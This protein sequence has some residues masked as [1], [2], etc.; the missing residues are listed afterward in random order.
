MQILMAKRE[1]RQSTRNVGTI[2][3]L[4]GTELGER[5]DRFARREK[6]MGGNIAMASA[7]IRQR[8]PKQYIL[9]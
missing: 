1:K 3:T 6:I 5:L 9:D 8:S 4:G 2:F 7:G